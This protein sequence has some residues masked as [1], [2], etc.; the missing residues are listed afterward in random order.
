MRHG[1]DAGGCTVAAAAAGGRRL[2][3]MGTAT[4]LET[5]RGRWAMGVG[6]KKRKRKEVKHYR[7]ARKHL[8]ARSSC[9]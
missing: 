8:K 4:A 5:D 1:G 3:E 2:P 7:N 6:H 9:M